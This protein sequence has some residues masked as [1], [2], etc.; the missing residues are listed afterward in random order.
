MNYTTKTLLAVCTSLFVVAC[1]K[2]SKSEEQPDK[3]KDINNKAT[4]KKD[5]QALVVP[6]KAP[7]EDFVKGTV[8]N[9]N[10]LSLDIDFENESEDQITKKNYK[11]KL[12]AFKKT[13]DKSEWTNPSKQD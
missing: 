12:K 2:P 5:P 3:G 8:S 13:G 10:R 11:E 7:T 4:T 1:N 9:Q 6:T